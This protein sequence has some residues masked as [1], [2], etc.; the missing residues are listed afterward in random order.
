MKVTP[1]TTSTTTNSDKNTAAS[2]TI[3]T[4]NADGTMSAEAGAYEGM[5]RFEMPE[6]FPEELDRLGNLVKVEDYTNKV[7][8]SE[9]TNAVVEPLSLQWFLAME[10]LSKPACRPS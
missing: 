1:A 5:D 2:E 6:E 3:D 4:I 8:R 9:R 7:G 10:K